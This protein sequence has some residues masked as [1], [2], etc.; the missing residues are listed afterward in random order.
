M[1]PFRGADGRDQIDGPFPGF[2]CMPMEKDPVPNKSHLSKSK[3]HGSPAPM[4][5]TTNRSEVRPI[6][7]RA[8]V[9]SGVL[10]VHRLTAALANEMVGAAVAYGAILG[11]K[12][13]AVVLD[14]N[15]IRQAQLRGDGAAIH[16]LDS[17]FHKA[18]TAVTFEVDTSTLVEQSKSGPVSTSI[19]K[20]PN[21]LLSQGGVIIKFGEE[22]IAAI[23]VGGAPGGDFDTR[24][25]KAG[26][27]KVRERLV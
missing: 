24:C 18:Y 10:T 25:A 8:K 22:P 23:G 2:I 6:D 26:L 3:R 27:D 11:Y 19:A 20:L 4:V 15:G 21:L 17:S 14:M 1:C 12:V 16:T 9:G 7:V 13:S 5:G